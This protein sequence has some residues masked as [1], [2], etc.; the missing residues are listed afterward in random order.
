MHLVYVDESGNTG[1]NLADPQQPIFVLCALIVPEDRWLAVE[2]DLRQAV[3]THLPAGLPSDTEIHATELRNGDGAFRGVSVPA[4]LALRDAWLEIAQQHDLK[5]ISRTIVKN[6]H[7]RWLQ[8]TFPA[9]VFI[10]P[11]VVAFPLMARSVNEY[12]RAQPGSPLGIFISDENKEI[13]GDV[14]KTIRLLRVDPT[15]LQLSQ[16]IEKG[17]FIDSKKSLH[18]QL[19]DLCT[20]SVRKKEEYKGG[21]P[22]KSIDR[23]GIE[24]IEPLVHRG[25][26]D[27]P[28]VLQWLKTQNTTP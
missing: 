10:N 27:L 28:D 18:L 25:N 4:R 12:L 9:G 13:V 7:A 21:R 14:E 26:E 2:N 22:L 6:R 11:H 15:R 19:C 23:G 1:K 8:E 5:L 3:T 24:R 20:Y 16:I 17:F